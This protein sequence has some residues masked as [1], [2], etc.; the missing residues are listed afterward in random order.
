M[1][2]NTKTHRAALDDHTECGIALE[3]AGPAYIP[4]C[5]PR[6]PTCGRCQKLLTIYPPAL[7]YLFRRRTTKAKRVHAAADAMQFVAVL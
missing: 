7:T 6:P 1:A 2:K 3:L 5:D 4:V